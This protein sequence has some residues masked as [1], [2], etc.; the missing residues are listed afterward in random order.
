MCVPGC[1]A[2]VHDQ[3]NRRGLFKAGAAALAAGSFA[4]AARRAEATGVRVFNRVVDLTHTLTPDFPT[5]LPD[6]ALSVEQLTTFAENGFNT[7]RYTMVEHCGTHI[8]APIHFAA[9]GA[10]AD[11][12]PLDDLVLPLAV[13]DVR[14]KAAE[15]PDYQLSPDDL[16]AWEEKYGEIPEGACIAMNSGWADKAPGDGFANRDDDGVMH[17]PG[18]HVEAADMLMSERGALGIAS[19]TLSLDHGASSTFETHYAWLPSGR[20]GVECIAGLD[21]VPAIGATVVVA[22]PKVGGGTGGNSR[23]MALV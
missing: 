22:A 13:I 16:M 15:N 5:Y 7:R 9:T 1:H 21:D 18:F 6:W 3:L 20:W 8:D 2:A 12:I 23:I 4:T 10:T 17:F 11:E 19:D 14:A